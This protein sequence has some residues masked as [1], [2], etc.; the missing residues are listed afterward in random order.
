MKAEKYLLDYVVNHDISIAQIEKD[1]G[2]NIE[3]RVNEEQ[4]LIA[5]E[6]LMLCT[7]LGITPEEVSDHIL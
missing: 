2:I 1:I 3:K 4:D 5:S 6:F 7:Y